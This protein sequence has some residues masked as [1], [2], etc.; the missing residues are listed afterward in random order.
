MI[1]SIKIA[2]GFI[3][4]LLVCS[5]A[6]AGFILNGNQSIDSLSLSENVLSF[7]DYNTVNSASSNTGF[8]ALDTFRFLITEYSG[9]YYL[10]GLIDSV[11]GTDAGKVVTTLTDSSSTAGSFALVDDA[12][13]S[14]VSGAGSTSITFKWGAG[15]T[16][17]FIYDLG[18]SSN[19]VNIQITLSQLV[20]LS[21]LSFLNFDGS[22]SSDIALG[23]SFTITADSSQD[24]NVEVSVPTS[25]ITFL[26]ALS[27]ALMFIGSHRR[28]N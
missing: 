4:S 28:P 15:Y 14:V 13:D 25:G 9:N 1:K 10:I 26:I 3:A 22:P 11:L 24:N 18:N 21:N 2:I 5:N 16:D 6:Q 23:T 20:N 8:E 27:L 7:Y 19:T 17:G 12:T